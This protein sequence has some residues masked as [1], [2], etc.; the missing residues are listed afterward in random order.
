MP[1]PQALRVA[2][3]GLGVG[4]F[5]GALPVQAQEMCVYTAKISAQDKINEAGRS[6]LST[7]SKSSVLAAIR[8]DRANFHR[9][10]KRDAEDEADCRFAS[11]AERQKIDAMVGQ[12]K[13]TPALIDKVA[14][15]EPVLRIQVFADR[16][17]I[18]EAGKTAPAQA[19]ATSQTCAYTAKI[20]AQD[21]INEAG[22]NILATLNKQSVLAAIRMDRANFHR[23]HKRDAED[24]ADCRFASLAERQKLD[25]MVV[26]T[27]LAS[28]LIEKVG[29]GEPVLRIQVFPD[30]LE[31]AE[32][33]KAS[34][35]SA[36]APALA[37]PPQT[38]AG[39]SLVGNAKTAEALKRLQKDSAKQK[40]LVKWMG[41]PQYAECSV[42]V[43]DID[44]K[45]SGGQHELSA[46]QW[47]L[48]PGMAANLIYMKQQLLAN[49]VTPAELDNAI[50]AVQS[51]LQTR[52]IQSAYDECYKAMR[53]AYEEMLSRK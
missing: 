8:M 44:Q 10:H 45:V 47:D 37:L 3:L 33:A 11:L 15:G 6:I 4:A 39:A 52:G 42:M 16:L 46:E 40:I 14:R 7:P 41:I 2:A 53:P 22:R 20:S 23:Y 24:E 12:T 27:V 9:Y 26:T 50:K 51:R 5:S 35:A 32:A 13:L 19:A 48:Y 34:P 36:P 28:A 49:K 29:H 1:M 30:R 21:K 18:A 31:V 17:E 38:A 43:A 25:G